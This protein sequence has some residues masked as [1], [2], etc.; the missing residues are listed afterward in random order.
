ML[1]KN[2][3]MSEEEMNMGMKYVKIFTTPLMMS[4]MGLLSNLFFSVIISLI[5][6]IFRKKRRTYCFIVEN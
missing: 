6:A 2:P 1:E 4:I 5:V 3:N